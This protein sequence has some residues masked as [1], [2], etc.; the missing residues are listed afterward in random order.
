MAIEAY[1]EISERHTLS[2]IT[3]KD[4]LARAKE[5]LLKTIEEVRSLRK[6]TS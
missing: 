2:I 5:S 3:Q 1:T 4:D 6:K